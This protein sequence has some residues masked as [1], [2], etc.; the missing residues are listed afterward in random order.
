MKRTVFSRCLELYPM[1]EW[2][3][4][5]Q[6]LNK[7]NRF[8]RKHRDFSRRY[9]AGVR[10]IEVDAHGHFLLPKDLMI[11]DGISKDI[12]LNGTISALESWDTE[13]YE[14]AIKQDA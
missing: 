14:K 7:L 6:Q 2:E 1:N 10:M 9:T 8:N 3:Q 12:T 11:H 4:T 5:M 13:K